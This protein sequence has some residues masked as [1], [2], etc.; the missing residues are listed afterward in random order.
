MILVDV[1]LLIYATDRTST[2]HEA[3]HEWLERQ[4][5]G[6]TVI[7]LPWAVLLAFVRLTTKPQLFENPLTP[8]VA[9]D[10]VDGW[11]ERE[12]VTVPQPGRRH[13]ELVRTLLTDP[14][15]GGN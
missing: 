10:L 1:N 14:G 9:M 6:A 12:N 8:G 3:A 11:L 2:V 4:F 7:A 5:N 15:T 13:A